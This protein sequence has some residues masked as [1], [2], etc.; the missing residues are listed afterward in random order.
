M[1]WVQCGVRGGE[2]VEVHSLNEKEYRRGPSRSNYF[3]R[4]G[5][6]HS[7]RSCASGPVFVFFCGVDLGRDC[8]DCLSPVGGPHFEGQERPPLPRSD[9]RAVWRS[10]FYRSGLKTSTVGAVGSASGA[11][12]S[13][14][15]S[16]KCLA[17][18]GE[19]GLEPRAAISNAIHLKIVYASHR[20]C[21]F[22]A[23]AFF[24]QAAPARG[25][26][27][28]ASQPARPGTARWSAP[29]RTPA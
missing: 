7:W 23:G 26:P 22:I 1:R 24:K 14:A 8:D 28:T 4:I 17:C 15:A 12:K 16:C 5:A 10:M 27:R 20:S 13:P 6:L 3:T 9:S 2:I 18:S 19:R 21:I 11:V 25:A 29:G